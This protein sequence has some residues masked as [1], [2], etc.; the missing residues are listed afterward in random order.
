MIFRRNVMKS[1]WTGSKG[2]SV[3]EAVIS[4]T[5]LGLVVTMSFSAMNHSSKSFAGQIKQ[6]YLT[7]KGEKAIRLMQEE[8]ADA[9]R[10]G[11]KALSINVDG[12]DVTFPNALVYFQVPTRYATAKDGDNPN[13]YAVRIAK[14]AIAYGPAPTFPEDFD[15]N[16]R[17]GWRD[18]FRMVPNEEDSGRLV[19]LQG[20][21]VGLL[22]KSADIPASVLDPTTKRT[23]NGFNCYRFQVDPSVSMG[24]FGA[25]GV[26]DEAKEDRD[27]DGDLKKESKFAIGYIERFYCVG[28]P[29]D[30]S[31]AVV[32]V[33]PVPES[34]ARIG[35]SKVIQPMKYPSGHVHTA[36][37]AKQM[38]VTNLFWADPLNPSR[39]DVCIYMIEVNEQGEPHIVR[40]QVTDFMRNNTK[41]VLSPTSGINGD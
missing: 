13:G 30:P 23:K 15:F 28:D 35:E 7:D 16:L 26:I 14:V 12:T 40:M 38:N 21:S 22:S 19:F 31:A 3:L 6:A 2:F 8:L 20:D 24:K 9:T 17:Y 37:S 36:D 34:I 11:V 32:S 4:A 39:I 25:N 41:Y 5:I 29:P 33:T 18:P 10:V 1:A 27:L